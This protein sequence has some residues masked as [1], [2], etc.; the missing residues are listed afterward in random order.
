MN[1]AHLALQMLVYLRYR[2]GGG[3][4]KAMYQCDDD[5]QM[6]GT[7]GSTTVRCGE[8]KVMSGDE[9]GH[10][11][12]TLVGESLLRRVRLLV[13]RRS[14]MALPREIEWSCPE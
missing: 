7:E 6:I 2:V 13:L 3:F 4:R 14:I 5:W 9:L 1:Y 8:T 12:G 10:L 11:F